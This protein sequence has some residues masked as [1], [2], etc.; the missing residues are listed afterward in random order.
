MKLSF[1]PSFLESSNKIL[2]FIL[3]LPWTCNVL[4]FY[5]KSGEYL[6]F[7]FFFCFCLLFYFSFFDCQA[8]SLHLRCLLCRIN[9]LTAM[10]NFLSKL[11][12]TL[13]LKTKTKKAKIEHKKEAFKLFFVLYQVISVVFIIYWFIYWY[14]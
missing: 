3:K 9:V 11:L 4:R 7:F 10:L 14:L 8:M 2:S 6:I 13:V 1:I 5:C 12:F